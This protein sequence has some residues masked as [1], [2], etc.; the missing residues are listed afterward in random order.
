MHLSY[1]LR[2]TILMVWFTSS[3]YSCFYFVLFLFCLS[4]E[5]VKVQL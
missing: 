1:L 5:L 4:V 2:P 3:Y